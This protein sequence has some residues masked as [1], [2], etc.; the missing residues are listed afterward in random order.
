MMAGL[1]TVSMHNHDVD[2]FIR[3][4]TNGFFAE[5]AE[6]IGEQLLFLEKNVAAK[7]KMAAASRCTALDVFNQ[8]RYL[9]DWGRILEQLVG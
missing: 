8:D 4:G 1:V 5:S 9:S 2:L 7:N 6:E 3:N